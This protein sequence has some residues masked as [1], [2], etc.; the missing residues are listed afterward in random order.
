MKINISITLSFI[1][2]EP[3]EVIG[4]LILQYCEANAVEEQTGIHR[5]SAT[6][7]GGLRYLK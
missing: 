2:S 5:K 1:T 3:L 6:E 4:D 7:D